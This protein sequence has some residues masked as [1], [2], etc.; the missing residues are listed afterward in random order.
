MLQGRNMPAGAKTKSHCG[1]GNG[2]A[3]PQLAPQLHLHHKVSTRILGTPTAPFS[4]FIF[5]HRVSHGVTQDPSTEAR[6][7]QAVASVAA[8]A[9]SGNRARAVPRRVLRATEPFARSTPNHHTKIE[10]RPVVAFP[11]W[12]YVVRRRAP[13]SCASGEP[14]L[15]APAAVPTA[16][17]A[18]PSAGKS[19]AAACA[20]ERSVNPI[21]MAS[22][23]R[24]R[25]GGFV[26]YCSEYPFV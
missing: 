4:P 15:G 13:Q 1:R 2:M 3:Q 9:I 14:L 16:P 24:Y 23:K 8:R 18:C 12:L 22:V 25:I 17:S 6:L 10:E 5:T 21:V 20:R 26:G 7:T 11:G 19:T